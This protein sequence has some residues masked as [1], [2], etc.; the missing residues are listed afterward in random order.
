MIVLTLNQKKHYTLKFKKNEHLVRFC[1][2][3]YSLVIILL[4]FL[5]QY[6]GIGSFLSLGDTLCC[7]LAGVLIFL[8]LIY[9]KP[10]R[11]NKF[12][13]ILSGIIIAFNFLLMIMFSSMYFSIA[14]SITIILKIIMYTVVLTVSVNHFSFERVKKFYIVFC[15]I[16][17]LYLYLQVV[18]H[19]ITGGYLPIFLKY[20]WLFSWEKRTEDL[21]YYYNVIYRKFRPSSLFLEPG[22]FALYVLPCIY[23]LLLYCKKIIIPILISIAVLL[24]TSGAGLLLC[25]VA[26]GAMLLRLVVSNKKDKAILRI[27]PIAVIGVIFIGIVVVI[28]VC[29]DLFYAVFNS[30]GTRVFRGFVVYSNFKPINMVFGVGINNVSSYMGYYNFTT[31]F[32]ELNLNFGTTLTKSSMEF[33]IFGIALFLGG[34]IVAWKKMNK[35]YFLVFFAFLF[36]AYMIFEDML[37]NFRM[38]FLCSLLLYFNDE[39][40]VKGYKKK[41]KV[42]FQIRRIY[43]E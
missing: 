17:S 27:V 21:A 3:C 15:V 19:K 23:Y 5:Y 13:L 20:D 4:P 18:Y 29:T 31:Q 2:N 9:N 32:D 43:N 8:D 22:Y 14:D 6:A 38:G 33:G 16:L 25:A 42:L 28:A 26:W 30:L 12:I 36:F 39:N 34:N 41:Y 11:F 35:S 10:I 7:V 40:R 24:S 37:F 1:E